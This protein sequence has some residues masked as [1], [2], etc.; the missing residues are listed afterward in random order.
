MKL[1]KKLAAVF[2]ATTALAFSSCS[3]LGLDN[4][5][6][7]NKV[8]SYFVEMTSS[9]AVALYEIAPNDTVKNKAGVDCVPASGEHVVSFYLRNPQKY[10]FGEGNMTLTVGDFEETWG[11]TIAQDPDDSAKIN[12]TYDQSFLLAYPLGT[13]ISPKV[14]LFHPVSHK[15]FGVFDKMKISSDSPP[16]SVQLACFQRDGATESD[17]YVV[18]FYLPDVTKFANS[19]SS[20]GKTDVHTF[21]I[22]G[23][24]KYLNVADKKIYNSATVDDEGNWTFTDEDTSISGTKPANLQALSD[25]PNAFAFT[26]TEADYQGSYVAKYMT[27]PETIGYYGDNEVTYSLALED[28]AG[29]SA[30][31]ATS[32]KA[33]RLSAPILQDTSGN[34]IA[35]SAVV[36]ADEETGFYTLRIVHDGKDEDGNACGS[37]NINYTIQRTGGSASFGDDTTHTLRGTAA[38]SATIKLPG[39]CTFTIQATASKNYYITSLKTEATGVRVTQPAVFYVRQTGDDTNGTG[40]KATPFRTVQKALDTFKE[41][42]SS[43]TPTPDGK[44][45]L[46]DGCKVYVMSDLSRPDGWTFPKYKS[47]RNAFVVIDFNAPVTIQGYGGTWTLDASGNS[48]TARSCIAITNGKLILKNINVTGAIEEHRNDTDYAGIY[49]DGGGSDN[50]RLDYQNGRVYGN[51]L[52]SAVLVTTAGTEAKLT[53]VKIENNGVNADDCA[54]YGA[55]LHVGGNSSTKAI[56]TN[57]DILNNGSLDKPSTGGAGQGGAVYVNE[58]RLEMTGGS[59][60]GTKMPASDA[61]TTQGGAVY[62]YD[63]YADLTNVEISGTR[64]AKHGG[65]IYCDSTS[66]LNLKSCTIKD[67]NANK[68]GAIYTKGMLTL[69]SCTITGNQA[70]SECAGVYTDSGPSVGLQING[71][72][73]I[74]DNYITGTTIQSNL[75]MPYEKRIDLNSS[76]DNSFYNSLIGVYV[77][78]TDHEPTVGDPRQFT[79]NYGYVEG[80]NFPPKPGI[81]FRSENGYGIAADATGNAAF[82]VSSASSYSATDYTFTPTLRTD[83]AASVYPGATKTFVINDLIGKRKEPAGDPSDIYFKVKER[84]LYTKSGTPVTDVPD[85]TGKTVSI[86]AALYSGGTKVRDATVD[87]SDAR[88][89]TLVAKTAGD[90]AIL[91]PNNYTLKVF[92]EFLGIKHEANIPIAIDYSA[93]TVA[94]YINRLSASPT[95]PVIVKGTVGYEYSGDYTETEADASDGGLAK[96]AKAIRSKTGT[97]VTIDLDATGTSYVPAGGNTSDPHYNPLGGY[98]YSYF[99]NCKALHSFK[100]PDWM[101]GV[102]PSL[103]ENCSGLT[104]VE[105]PDS[106]VSVG[107]SAFKDCSNLASI[108]FGGTSAEWK[109]VEFGENWR[110]GVTQT[111]KVHCAGDNTD[112]PFGF[113]EVSYIKG[114]PAG[115]GSA[116]IPVSGSGTEADPFIAEGS[117]VSVTLEADTDDATSGYTTAT[118]VSCSE[119]GGRYVLMFDRNSM[120]D[121]PASGY[122]TIEVNF[123]YGHDVYFKIMPVT[124]AAVPEGFVVVEGSTVVGSNKFMDTVSNAGVFVGGRSVAISTFWICDHEVTQKEYETYCKYGGTA[125]PSDEFGKGDNYPAYYVNW[126]DAIVYCNLRSKAE[127]LTPCYKLKI[128]GSYKNFPDEWTDIVQE[129]GKYC[130]PSSANSDWNGIEFD[131]SANGYRLPTEAEWEYAARGGKAGCEADTPTDWAGTDDSAELGKYAWYTSNSENKTHAVKTNKGSGTDSANSLGIYDMSGNVFEWCWDW[132]ASSIGASTPA[133]GASSGD[134]R[135]NHGGSWQNDASACSVAFRNNDSPFSRVNSRGFRVVRTVPN[136]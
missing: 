5:S 98:V 114:S 21:Y 121:L 10:R 85:P 111:N 94:D 97:G 75:Y 108:T 39:R 50:P 51:K 52:A 62:V 135:V 58:G 82:A 40:A 87:S 25:D 131:A 2:A 101:L 7:Q 19:Y 106:V 63:G 107:A 70:D 118:G 130:G 74:Y 29:L 56:L 43:E 86:S 127:D 60:K 81:V 45:P 102:L 46:G 11:A 16:P 77:D 125:A 73:T 44:Y 24:K 6:F 119:V 64:G 68:Y 49:V 109:K 96:V 104:S 115:G 31:M 23:T 61:G 92:V 18:C 123:S 133:T 91:P 1:L 66:T 26:G 76:G 35:S 126:Y 128:G 71:K 124:T 120:G 3:N 36:T 15:S 84:T 99:K 117:V 9:A 93:E 27:L 72:N 13:N 28:D 41:N 53:N 42:A 33:S 12:I 54:Q 136:P 110:S 103:F 30:G 122:W 132:F 90:A 37:V 83:C 134:A 48:G 129:D 20:E 67:N 112:V 105:I 22:N 59:I 34:A 116:T 14:E 80:Q 65:A 89:I 100:M 8:S 79:R 38:G 17:H 95:N 57:C 69:D 88:R 55:A 78:L 113:F 4:N 32:N 47:S